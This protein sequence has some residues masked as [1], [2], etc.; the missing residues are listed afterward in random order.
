MVALL[1]STTKTVV[2]DGTRNLSRSEQLGV[3]ITKTSSEDIRALLADIIIRDTAQQRAA[4]NDPTIVDVDGSKSRPIKDVRRRITVLFGTN[5]PLAALERL[6]SALLAN[7]RAST[8][9]ISGRLSSPG[10]WEF[11]HIRNGRKVPLSSV[12][13]FGSRDFVVLRPVLGYATAVNKRVASGSKSF[14]YRASNAKRG[15]TAKKNQRLGFMAMTARQARGMA[16]FVPFSVTVG[17]TH[18]FRIPGEVSKQGTAYLI[19]APRRKRSLR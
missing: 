17:F 6:K 2:I 3:D 1:K 15:K 7:I 8:Q 9:A 5:L 11:T 10:S 12:V 4:G 18:A 14:E 16:E 13:N 19:I